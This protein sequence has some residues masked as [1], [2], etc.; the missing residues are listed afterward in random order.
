MLNRIKAYVLRIVQKYPVVMAG[1]FIYGY[2]LT[3]TLNFFQHT[4]K[5]QRSF[6]DFVLE[7]DS[8]IWMWLA[9]FAFIKLQSVKDKFFKDE[10]EKLAIRHE[11]Q[12]STLASN[13]LKDITKQ[14]QDEIN[15]PLTV[16]SMMSNDIRKK[17]TEDADTLRRLD[18]IESS[19]RR[20]HLAIKDVATY[21]SNL[22]LT[23]LQKGIAE[24][25]LKE[26]DS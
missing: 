13:M 3:T 9:A 17:S 4:G 12:M 6:L 23:N 2:Y 18:Q 24:E 14:L 22:L 16:I 19:I 8:L 7:F 26:T 10:K 20:I 25:G 15:N 11:L 1:V 21:Q 5:G